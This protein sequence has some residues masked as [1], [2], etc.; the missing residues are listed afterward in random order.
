[1]KRQNWRAAVDRT[2]CN[3]RS[4]RIPRQA[5]RLLLL[6][7]S[8]LRGVRGSSSVTVAVLVRERSLRTSPPAARSCGKPG[9]FLARR[10]GREGA[11]VSPPVCCDFNVRSAL[12]SAKAWAHHAVQ[13]FSSRMH[14]THQAVP[15]VR[16]KQPASVD[17]CGPL[18]AG[19]RPSLRARRAQSARL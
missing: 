10:P 13:R 14:D 17:I 8:R 9:R 15:G 4:T 18:D 2:A 11:F 1:M 16:P 19:T 6:Q 3:T 5:C 7:R 12:S